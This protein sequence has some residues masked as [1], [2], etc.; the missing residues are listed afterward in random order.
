MI[1]YSFQQGKGQLIFLSNTVSISELLKSPSVHDSI[2]LKL[3]W[4]ADIK[5]FAGDTLGLVANDNY[6][7]YYEQNQAP[8]LWVVTACQPYELKEY[9]WKY[10]ILGKL[11]YKGFLS[12][13][14]GRKRS[15]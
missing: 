8:I 9:K 10:P 2:K 11:G 7:T 4:V 5:K 6:T 13:G 12:Q 1:L 15:G 14:I 3:S